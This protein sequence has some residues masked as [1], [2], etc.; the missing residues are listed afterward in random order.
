MLL[1][2]GQ[3]ERYDDE[4]KKLNAELVERWEKARDLKLFADRPGFAESI[5]QQ[6]RQV[7]A[8]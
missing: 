7:V 1:V 4:Q 8:T 3:P 5:V 2:G 6:P